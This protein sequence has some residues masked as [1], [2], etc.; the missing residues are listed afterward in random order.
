MNAF[1]YNYIPCVNELNP[2]SPPYF[3]RVFLFQKGWAE[4]KLY[5]REGDSLAYLSSEKVPLSC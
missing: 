5:I 4:N 2:I 3:Y 1:A